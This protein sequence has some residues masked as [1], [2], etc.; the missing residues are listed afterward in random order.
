MGEAEE[1][2]EAAASE[3]GAFD[4]AATGAPTAAPSARLCVAYTG[5]MGAAAPVVGFSAP[6]RLDVEANVAAGGGVD[7]DKEAA[8]GESAEREV[9]LVETNEASAL[10]MREASPSCAVCCHGVAC[11]LSWR[12]KR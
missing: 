2:E 1:E 9:P 10:V 7:V 4:D 12:F 11:Q 8:M 3:P 6:S 5:E